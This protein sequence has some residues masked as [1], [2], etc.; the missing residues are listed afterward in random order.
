M[1]QPTTLYVVAAQPLLLAD[2]WPLPCRSSAV[3]AGVTDKLG[4]LAG[5]TSAIIL[6]KIAS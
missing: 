4:D 1:A 5:F 3:H 2:V 6:A